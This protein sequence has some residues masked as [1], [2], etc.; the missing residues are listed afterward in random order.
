MHQD[1]AAEGRFNI[2]KHDGLSPRSAWTHSCIA[3]PQHSLGD[4][5]KK[6][7]NFFGP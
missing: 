2:S 4:F 5:R 7:F 1:K 6:A 3:A